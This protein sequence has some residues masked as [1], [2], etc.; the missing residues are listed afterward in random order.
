MADFSQTTLSNAFSWMKILEFRLQIHWSLFLRV[1]LTTF[2]HWFWQ[3]LGADQ[4]TSHYLNQCWSDHWRIYASLGLN[5]LNPIMVQ[6]S[7]ISER[8]PCRHLHTWFWN[9]F[10]SMEVL[11]S[12]VNQ[13]QKFKYFHWNGM[14]F[15][16]LSAE[17]GPFFQGSM[18]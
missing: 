12:L 10:S 11:K 8:D 7:S 9:T 3:W 1:L 6:L 5:E 4:A 2:Q 13:Y 16:I 17:Y 14:H 15:K 18:T